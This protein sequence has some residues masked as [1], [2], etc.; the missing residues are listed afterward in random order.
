MDYR[1]FNELWNITQNIVTTNFQENKDKFLF[2]FI[3]AAVKKSENNW[4][5]KK[6]Y[7]HCIK[8][9]THNIPNHFSFGI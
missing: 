9:F 2:Y 5:F 7:N 6:N 1:Y 3:F 4:H 8:L